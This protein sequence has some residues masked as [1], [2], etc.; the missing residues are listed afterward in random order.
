M[1][2]NITLR[3]TLRRAGYLTLAFGLPVAALHA[4]TSSSSS[5]SSSSYNRA[6]DQQTY[7]YNQKPPR[8]TGKSWTDHLILEG[9]GGGTTAAGNTQNYANP[10]FNILLGAGFKFNNRLSIL[11]EWNFNRMGVP[12]SLA[13]IIAGTPGGNE[14]IWTADLNPKFNLIRSGRTDVYVIGGGGFSRALT[15]FTVPVIVPCGYG[16]GF[17]GYG[18]GGCSGNITVAHTS[19]NQANLDVGGGI[20]FR[21]SPY[22]REKLFVEAR[23]VKLYSPNKGSIPPGY[24]ATLVPATIGVRW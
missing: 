22:H 20:E 5:S 17:Y 23:Y 18:Y 16:Y 6:Y 1:N 4:Q 2:F 12:Q 24:D 3:A 19:T 21:F 7:N 15:N 9:G 10:G 11:A 14:H 13:G 8:Y